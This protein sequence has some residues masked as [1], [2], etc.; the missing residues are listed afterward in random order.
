MMID[1]GF[2]IKIGS[3]PVETWI[4]AV[5]EPFPGSKPRSVGIAISPL[6]EMN[7]AP[8]RTFKHPLPAFH[9]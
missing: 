1:S 4:T 5:N 3:T 6:V 9:T 2:P 7:V 8:S